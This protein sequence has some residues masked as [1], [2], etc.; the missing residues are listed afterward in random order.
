[1]TSHDDSLYDL[2]AHLAGTLKRVRP[3]SGLTQRMRDRVRLAEPRLLAAR[4]SDWR[5]YF[6]TVGGVI[7]GLLLIVTVARALFHL[8]GRRGG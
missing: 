8:T 6:L 2:E 3:P 1:M 4:L 7:S 5:F